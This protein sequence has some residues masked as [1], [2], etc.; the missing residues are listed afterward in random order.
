MRAPFEFRIAEAGYEKVCQRRRAQG[1]VRAGVARYVSCEFAYKGGTARRKENRKL[2]IGAESGQRVDGYR[3]RASE[4][5]SKEN[6]GQEWQQ[7]QSVARTSGVSAEGRRSARTLRRRAK[8]VPEQQTRRIRQ[9]FAAHRLAVARTFAYRTMGYS[10]IQPRRGTRFTGFSR[11]VLAEDAATAER[12]RLGQKLE[13]VSERSTG[14]DCTGQESQ[15]R[16]VRED[17][18]RRRADHSARSAASCRPQCV[19]SRPNRRFAARARCLA[20]RVVITSSN[21]VSRISP[22]I[23]A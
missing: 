18:A 16:F 19:S 15:D 20:G 23:R 7:R 12:C 13:R 9:R 8:R 11:R 17:S 1:N 3:R 4:K 14:N 2:G 5:S 6:S 21:F 10:R 22:V